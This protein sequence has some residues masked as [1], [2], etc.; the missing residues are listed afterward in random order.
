VRGQEVPGPAHRPLST[1]LLQLLGQMRGLPAC[2]DGDQGRENI[3][4]LIAFH[5]R[6]PW[7]VLSNTFEKMGPSKQNMDVDGIGR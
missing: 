6:I 3:W 1:W 2:P 4:G 5:L 7:M